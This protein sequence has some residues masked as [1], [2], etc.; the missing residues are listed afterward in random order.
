MTRRSKLVWMFAPLAIAFIGIA[1][2]T[3]DLKN[4]AI[5]QDHCEVVATGQAAQNLKT[6]SNTLYASSD[7][8]KNNV[9]LSCRQLG[10]V[11]INDFIVFKLNIQQGD[12]VTVTQ[13]KY[14][15]LPNRW[16]V[17]IRQLGD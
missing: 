10:V 12:P 8:M 3:V 17:N 6:E 13:K 2:A 4:P 5:F 1:V 7:Q 9:G 16:Q 14:Q 11:V 15:I